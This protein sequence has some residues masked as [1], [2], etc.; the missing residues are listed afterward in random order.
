MADDNPFRRPAELAKIGDKDAND[1]MLAVGNA[2]STWE[3]TERSFAH[4]FAKL[5]SPP[6]SGFAAQRAYGTIVATAVRRQ[7]I[8]AAAEVFF[9]NFPNPDAASEL[10]TLLEFYSTATG[11]RNDF[12]HGIVG[13]DIIDEQF[14]R[15]LVPNT[16]GARSRR[17]NLQ[18]DYRYSSEQIRDYEQKFRDLGLRAFRA[19]GSPRSNLSIISRSISR[20]ILTGV[21]FSPDL[22]VTG[23]ANALP[24]SWSELQR[25]VNR[26]VAKGGSSRPP[27]PQQNFMTRP[28]AA[29][30]PNA[31]RTGTLYL[32]GNGIP[33]DKGDPIL[34]SLNLGKAVGRFSR[35]RLR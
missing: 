12:A 20:A 3:H 18:I 4:I 15:F 14:W 23:L 7:M 34:P 16:W 11:R 10:A 24:Y 30:E 5:V 27:M 22:T 31:M 9:R 1:I 21:T 2:L 33:P 28:A 26:S 6:A 17:M 29:G 35:A 13:G 19:L 8:E 32:N 25:H